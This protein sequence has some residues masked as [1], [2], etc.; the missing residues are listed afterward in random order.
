MKLNKNLLYING[1]VLL[2]F[3]LWGAI[4]GG[5]SGVGLVFILLAI[6]NIPVL[7]IFLANKK[8]E[9]VKTSLL[10]I[11]VF[12]LIGWSICSNISYGVAR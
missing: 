4:S 9:A 11:G 7:V 10:I 6:F 2:V 3:G 5:S 1:I 12:L 8:W